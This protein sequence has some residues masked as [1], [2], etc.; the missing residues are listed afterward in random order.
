MSP[1]YTYTFSRLL[2][3]N[4]TTEP[5]SHLAKVVLDNSDNGLTSLDLK[6]YQVILNYGLL[7]EEGVEIYQPMPPLWCGGQQLESSEGRLACVL[8][9]IGIPNLLAEDRASVKY[10]PLA[11][12]TKV[13][14]TIIQD[15]FNGTMTAFN[16]C[17]TYTVTFGTMD[18]LMTTYIPKDSFRIY[19]NGSR[20]AALKKLLDYTKCV[21]RFES[22]GAIHI[23]Q[24]TISGTTY[25]YEYSL[26]E[27]YHTFWGKA[28]RKRLVIP[29]KIVV[30][31]REDDTP[32]YTGSAVDTDSYTA[33][34]FYQTQFEE[35]SLTSNAQ[36]TSIAEAILSKYQ[37][38]AEAGSGFVPMNLTAQL[39]DYVKITDAREQDDYRIGNVGRIVRTV[40]TTKKYTEWSTNFSFG[41]WLSV[42]KIANDLELSELG[43]GN[44][45]KLMVKDLYAENISAQQLYIYSHQLSGI[46]FTDNSPIAGKVSWS[47]GEVIYKGVTYAITAGNTALKY[48]WWDLTTP[49]AFQVSAT[50]PTLTD[51]DFIVAIN[52]SGTHRMVWDAT[53]IDG[54][55]II[56]GTISAEE[57]IAHTITTDE[58]LMSGLLTY[59]YGGG[60]KL[61][62]IYGTQ[63]SAGYLQLTSATVK[64]GEWYNEHGV[65][66]DA[67]T[68]IN[69]YGTDQALTTRATKTGTI[70]C[71]V[72]SGGKIVAGAGKVTLSA[73]GINIWGLNNALTTR[74]TETGTIQCYVG[75]DGK[76]YAGAGAVILDASG[77][78]IDFGAGGLQ[79]F[80]LKYGAYHSYIF[81]GSGGILTLDSPNNIVLDCASGYEISCGGTVRPF[82]TGK[83]LGI[84]SYIWS[85]GYIRNLRPGAHELG[86]L[87]YPTEAY[88]QACVKWLYTKSTGW[89]SYQKH[90]DIAL[91][92]AIKTKK[93]DGKDI[94]DVRTLPKELVIE[95]EYVNMAGV[96]GLNIGIMKSLLTRIE[97][98]EAR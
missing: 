80:D 45:S 25:T 91:L 75:S 4:Y 19:T 74:A 8:E 59:D 16:H 81:A 15:M 24:P 33:L 2:K 96:V 93:E 95:N 32:Q 88:L 42:R 89:V 29:N 18:S 22:D 49:T 26:A 48:I 61:Q 5:F 65:E 90:D 46:T 64:D 84:P 34:G 78:V 41:G 10:M 35:T 21:A 98:L 66:I 36:A 3:L 17:K 43:V 57:I 67:D 72:D 28:Y 52:S 37:M 1:T 60:K 71:K 55:T 50:K 58:I 94:I 69:I 62:S 92:K 7:N 12:D 9:L 31:S 27:G 82:R 39:Y 47:A 14:K 6:G 76:I 40:D 51:D 53:L 56:T 54:G 97:A 83:D 63:I 87:G 20:L 23:F 44:F 77:L 86:V 11:T 85:T 70:Q 73:S 68:G 13:V 30:R 38:W 79:W